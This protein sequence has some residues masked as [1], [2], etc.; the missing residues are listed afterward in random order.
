MSEAILDAGV[1]LDAAQLQAVARLM[2]RYCSAIDND[3]LE[4]WPG[5]FTEDGVYRILTRADY[6]AGRDFGIWFC[7]NRRMLQDRVSA[8]RSVNVYEPHCYRHVIG[9]TEILSADG[10][11]LACETSYHLVRI[12]ADGDMQMFSVGRY[13]D[14]VAFQ[15]GA[16]LLASRTVV[17]DSSRY[18]TL[19][20]LPI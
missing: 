10:G 6:R 19:V 16:A 5:F 11:L 3:E 4:R 2:A 14:R 7:G 12:D 1:H 9:P 20:A 15:D 18:D 13:I 8:T 17:T